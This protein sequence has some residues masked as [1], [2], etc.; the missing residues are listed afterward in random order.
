MII[1]RQKEF[2]SKAQK[3]MRRKWDLEQAMDAREFDNEK[4]LKLNKA[5]SQ[6]SMLGRKKTEELLDKATKQT[7]SKRG[8]FGFGKDVRIQG[9]DQKE[10]DEMENSI[11]LLRAGRKRSKDVMDIYTHPNKRNDSFEKNLD[12]AISKNRGAGKL[13][14]RTLGAE[15]HGRTYILDDELKKQIEERKERMS[16]KNN[17]KSSDKTKKIND[18][19]KDHKGAVIGGTL[20]AAALVGGGIAIKKARDKKKRKESEKKDK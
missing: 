18:F 7:K 6:D 14:F 20:G 16:A 3:A 19:I 9:K 15:K 2:N 13:N 11:N 12:R 1:L 8:P 17:P 4:Q 10:L 5:K